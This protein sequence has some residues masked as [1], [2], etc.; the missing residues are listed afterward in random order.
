MSVRIWELI[1]FAPPKV[2]QAS[3]LGV[4]LLVITVALVLVQYR[5]LGQRSF[6]TVTG[7]GLR[8]EP[9]ALGRARWPLAAL[10]FA[11]IVFVVLVPYAALLFIALRKNLFYATLGAIADPAQLSFQHFAVAFSDPVVRLSLANSL[12]VSLATLLLG[13]V[14]YFA[15]AYT[16]HRTQLRG[17]RALDLIAVLP[18]AIPG[19]IIGL[20]YLWSW[21]SFPIGIYGTLWIIILAYISQFSPQGVRA[22]SGSLVQIHPELE[23]SSRLCGAGFAYTLRR[24]VVPLAWPG[25]LSAMILLLILSFRELATALFLYT[26]GTQVFS[27]TMF[28][29]WLRG[30]TNL[31]AVMALVQTVLLV[32]LVVIGQ[33]IRRDHTIVPST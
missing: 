15:V 19:L 27:L 16:V 1:G 20:G 9:V 11:Y 30:S 29:F 23:E 12:T 8:P 18:V 10:G 14:L 33:R 24:I 4:L 13:S 21:I 2:N 22:I 25:I 26:S 17:R 28:D 31:V 3:A 5:V 32:L 6:V 7:K